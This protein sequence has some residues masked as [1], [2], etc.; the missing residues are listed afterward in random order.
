MLAYI[1]L[2]ILCLILLRIPIVFSIG[3]GCLLLCLINGVDTVVVP[4]RIFVTLDVF[5]FLAIPLFLLAGNLM[6]IGGVTERLVNFS[7]ALVGYITGGLG[8]AN[9]VAN[10]FMAGMSGSAVADAAGLGSVEI[11]IMT[12]AG[13]DLDFSAALSCAAAT[14]GPI[15]PPSIIM[16]VYSMIS[17]T[18]IGRLFIGGV[19]PGIVMGFLSDD[20]GLCHRT[21]EKVSRGPM[22]GL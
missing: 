14:I 3:I 1:I 19:L 12:K 5:T 9:V 15:I 10:M 11:K 2:F 8:H 7:R 16:V 21:E 17:N 4:Q 13:Y 22:A 6:N 20:H 18:S